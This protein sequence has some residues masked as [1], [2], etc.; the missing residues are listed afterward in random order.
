[1]FGIR[2]SIP[3][4]RGRGAGL[5]NELIPW[6]RSFV[7]GKLIGA[8]CLP[9]AFGLNRRRYWRHF[10]TPRYDWLVYR[11]LVKGLPVFHFKEEDYERAGGQDL[12]AAVSCFEKKHRLQERRYYAILTE[13][14]WGGRHHIRLAREF[15]RSTLYLS[16]FAPAK[17]MELQKRVIPECIVVGMHI[18][19]GDFQSPVEDGAMEYQGRFNLA[20]PANYYIRVALSLMAQ[21]GKAVQFLVVSDASLNELQ[22]ILARLPKNTICTAG[23]QDTDCS[24]LLALADADLIVCSI[25]SFSLWAAFLSESPYLWFQPHL[26]QH[27]AGALSIWGFEEKQRRENSP[28][29][30]SILERLKRLD[31]NQ[32]RGVP[33]GESGAVPEY[34]CDYL[35]ERK[36]MMHRSGDLV[37]YGVAPDK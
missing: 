26:H 22:P 25:S 30:R 34:L 24:D 17:L 15:A 6:A 1:M 7:I 21:M 12:A 27:S 16:R 4:V 10:G 29:Q 9:P 11:A 31:I 32:I 18:R 19:R 36:E 5:G 23:E 20:L 14:M 33:I 37:L 8:K 13:G 3:W 2:L 35:I 28:T